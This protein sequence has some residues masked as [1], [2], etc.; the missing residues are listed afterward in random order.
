MEY[1]LSLPPPVDQP[2]FVIDPDVKSLDRPRDEDGVLRWVSERGV[3]LRLLPPVDHRG[4]SLRVAPP[5]LPP[6]DERDESPRTSLLLLPPPVDQR[7]DSDR[8][9]P[10]EL[11][12]P[13]SPLD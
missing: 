4:L 12:M 1:P 3:S 5:L 11:R 8:L 10:T 6:V 9:E 7:G 13:L 2:P